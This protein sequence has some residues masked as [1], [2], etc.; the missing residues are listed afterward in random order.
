MYSLKPEMSLEEQN[1][2]Q[3]WP[4]AVFLGVVVGFVIGLI[5]SRRNLNSLRSELD[6]QKAELNRQVNDSM[7]TRELQARTEAERDALKEQLRQIQDDRESLKETFQALS[8]EQFEKNRKQFLDHAEQRLSVSEA[9]HVTELDKRHESIEKQF[10]SVKEQMDR[11][12]RKVR[13]YVIFLCHLIVGAF[14]RIPVLLLMLRK[15][16]QQIGRAHV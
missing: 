8:A 9:K 5:F 11:F 15:G 16:Y 4:F 14:Y 10:V 13:L 2:E 12:E 7:E 3:Y 1:M 6:Q